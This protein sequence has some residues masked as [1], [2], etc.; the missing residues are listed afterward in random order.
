MNHLKLSVKKQIILSIFF[1]L[2]YQILLAQTPQWQ[3]VKGGGSQSNSTNQGLIENSKWIGIDARSNIYSMSSVFDYGIKIDTS[4][5]TLGFGYDDFAVFSYRCDG[6]LRWVRYF[7]NSS[8]DIPSGLFTDVDGNSFVAGWVVGN[9]YNLINHYGDSTR[10]QSGDTLIPAGIIA[11]LDSNGHT[12]WISFGALSPT[13]GYDMVGVQPDNQGNICLLAHFTGAMNW[14]AFVI[15]SKG[16]YVLKFN[17]NN[18]VIIGVTKLDYRNGTGHNAVL[19]FNF[20]MDSDNSYYVTD[21]IYHSDSIIV[22]NTIIRCENDS[23]YKYSLTKFN[24]NGSVAWYKILGGNNFTCTRNSISGKAVIKGDYVYMIG[25]SQNNVS[26]YGTIVTNPYQLY[27]YLVETPLIARFRKDNGNFVSLKNIYNTGVS[28]FQTLVAATNEIVIAGSYGGNYKV[29]F[30]QNDTLKPLTTS[31]RAFPFLLGID[32][33]LSYFN[34]GIATKTNEAYSRVQDMIV[35]NA[36]NIFAGGFFGDSL[37]NS[38]GSGIRS[39][40]GANDFFIAKISTTNNCNCSLS[41][42]YPSLVSITNKIVTVKGNATIPQDSLYWFWG[43]GSK[44]KYINQNTNVSHTYSNVGNYTVCLKTY[45]YCGTKDSCMAVNIVGV[46]EQELKYLNVYPNPVSNSLSLENPYQ[47]SMQLK[48][49][50][51]TGKL[52]FNNTYDKDTTTIDISNL[53]AGIYFIEIQLADG[54]RSVKKVVKQ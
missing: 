23:V 15:P 42:P 13:A 41:Q 40:G 29:I 14:G 17:K 18:G 28:S 39:Q 31:N 3:W 46:N 9:Q 6:S 54:R 32:T 36:G 51:I 30:N 19:S 47:C 21:Y 7:G 27:Y 1:M 22:G 8:N 11:K 37:Y 4:E 26:F 5:K 35:D 20:S 52:L 48:I 34:W 43:D 2:S 24:A 25:S 50:N 10:V 44:T 49:Y 16:Y 12:V 53:E 33:A 45:N 38:F